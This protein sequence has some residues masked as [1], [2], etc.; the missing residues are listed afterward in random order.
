MVTENHGG[1]DGLPVLNSERLD[2]LREIEEYGEPGFLK[3]LAG[4]F[5]DAGAEAVQSIQSAIERGQCVEIRKAAHKLK[6][7]SANIGADRLAAVC[8]EMEK[9]AESER[10]SDA[11]ACFDRL[12]RELRQA[13]EALTGQELF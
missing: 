7:A 8:G 2:E 11:N 6:G 13:E 10:F 3:E 9:H 1:W 12:Q 5:V 4:I